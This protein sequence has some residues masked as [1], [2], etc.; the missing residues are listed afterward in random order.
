M[1]A[2]KIVVGAFM[3]LGLVGSMLEY[4]NKATEVEDP[5]GRLA[6]QEEQLLQA[7][8]Q[9]VSAI[10]QAVAQINPDHFGPEVQSLRLFKEWVVQLKQQAQPIREHLTQFTKTLTEY[11][12]QLEELPGQCRDNAVKLR[13][14]AAAEDYE[15][16]KMD[17][18]KW[19]DVLDHLAERIVNRSESLRND[20]QLYRETVP[21]VEHTCLLL[22][23][24]DTALKVVPDALTVIER[25]QADLQSFIDSFE[26]FETTL[27]G[28]HKTVTSESALAETTRTAQWPG[29][30]H[31]L[32]AMESRTPQTNPLQLSLQKSHENPIAELSEQNEP[33]RDRSAQT[34]A[35]DGD[36]Y[37][38]L[39]V[40]TESAPS[41]SAGETYVSAL[42]LNYG[43]DQATAFANERAW[44]EKMPVP[45]GVTKQDIRDLRQ[46]LRESLKR[47]ETFTASGPYDSGDHQ[48]VI[49]PGVRQRRI[50]AE[51]KELD[52]YLQR[53]S[54]ANPDDS[55]S[56]FPDGY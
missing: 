1:D 31:I 54:E 35:Y 17:Y 53:R 55:E 51:E 47:E 25:H 42:G 39:D 19:A 22:D 52:D 4:K 27:E 8:E 38:Q 56:P 6:R 15:H 50:Q 48:E 34:I 45:R 32:A 33:H 36:H 26:R 14:H 40:L 5:A 49:T 24:L 20:V 12:Q 3:L 30:R 10:E 21:Q 2:N 41:E 16:L 9:L 43:E 13:E 37:Q 29:K 23:R 44:R 18:L 11:T 7:N 28:L 46:T